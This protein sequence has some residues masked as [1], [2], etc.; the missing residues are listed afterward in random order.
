MLRIAIFLFLGLVQSC[1]TPAT[2]A[3]VTAKPKAPTPVISPSS[4]DLELVMVDVGQ[5]DGMFLRTPDGKTIVVDAGFKGRG[6]ALVS[7]LQSR[8]VSRI[9]L[10]ILSHPHADH[11]GGAIHLSRMDRK[12]TIGQIVQCPSRSRA[13]R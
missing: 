4:N 6:R 12:T 2:N 5:G 13:G 8:G 10:L 11:I 3:P 1:A 7:E 9:D